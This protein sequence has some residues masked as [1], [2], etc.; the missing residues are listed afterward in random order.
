MNSS[1]CTLILS[2]IY[3]FDDTYL[4]VL[5]SHVDLIVKTIIEHIILYYCAFS[6]LKPF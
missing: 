6:W 2:L 4:Y 5:Y 3:D 1:K